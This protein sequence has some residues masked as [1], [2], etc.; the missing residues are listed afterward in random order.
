[1][2]APKLGRAGRALIIAPLWAPLIVLPGSL[3]LIF[4]YLSMWQWVVA[5]TGVSAFFSYIGAVVFGVPA[6]RFMRSRGW[7]G[8]GAAAGFG[9]LHGVLAWAGF[10]ICFALLMHAT[11][12]DAQSR[13][14]LISFPL[15]GL[16]GVMIAV[17]AWLVARPDRRN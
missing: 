16:L 3:F 12:F 5:A 13:E 7:T 9:L 6:F 11:L 14:N 15:A 4:P 2:A 8:F 17:T 10:E 1:M